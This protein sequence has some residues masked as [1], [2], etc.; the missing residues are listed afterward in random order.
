LREVCQH[1]ESEGLIQ[2]VPRRGYFVAL[3]FQQDISN[4]FQLR[5]IEPLLA[6]RPDPRRRAHPKS[7]LPQAWVEAFLRGLADSNRSLLHQLQE[8]LDLFRA[9]ESSPERGGVYPIFGLEIQVPNFP[10]ECALRGV[11]GR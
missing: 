8:L 2:N 9:V 4:L 6:V 1:L 10:M 5:A 11:A 7:L 3:F